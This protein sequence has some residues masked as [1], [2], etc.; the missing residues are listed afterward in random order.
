MEN[1]VPLSKMYEE[2]NGYFKLNYPYNGSIYTISKNNYS[3]DIVRV[4]FSKEPG[5][6]LACDL[7]IDSDYY[8]P[9]PQSTEV[10]NGIT[11][12]KNRKD[13]FTPPYGDIYDTHTVIWWAIYSGRYY[14][15]QAPSEAETACRRVIRTFTLTGI[16]E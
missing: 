13:T 10:Y 6:G 14:R 11:W 5:Q 4:F 16:P 2:P 15:W 12:H 8:R 9:D 1:F 7:H 3:P